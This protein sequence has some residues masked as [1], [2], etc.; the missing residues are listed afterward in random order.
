[1]IVNGKRLTPKQIE[2][3][4][5]LCNTNPDFRAKVEFLSAGGSFRDGG[6]KKI[7]GQYVKP[8]L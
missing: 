7:N 6:V 3:Y 2:L 1:M 8:S 4:M 5:T